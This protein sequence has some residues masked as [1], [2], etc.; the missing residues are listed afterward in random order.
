MDESSAA[1]L[2]DKAEVSHMPFCFKNPNAEDCEDDP[3]YYQYTVDVAPNAVFL[4]LCTVSLIGILGTWV[5]TRRGTAFNVAMILGLVCEIVGYAARIANWR[6][7][8]DLTAFITQICCLTMGPA[9]MAAGIYLCLRR[10]VT[11]F[12]P[13]NSRLPPEY[14]TRF[15]I[16]C[17]IV[18]LFLQAFGGGVVAVAAQQYRSTR[19]GT[20]IMIAGLASQAATILVF[21]I[22]SADFALRSIRRQRV[23]G[24]AAFDQRAEIA[25]VRNSRRFQSF[26][27][28]LSLSA[29][30]ILS[31]SAFR[32]AELSQGWTGSLMGNQT[33]FIIF[34]GIL[35]VVAVISLNI[36][37]PS[38]CM[39]ELLELEGGGLKGIWGFRIRNEATANGGPVEYHRK[40]PTSESVAI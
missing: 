9:F 17:D 19:L 22:C 35:I 5:I 16:P 4:A 39:K 31:R 37:H 3:G 8:F 21:I 26:I 11:A 18:S 2:F 7:R 38:F 27:C 33:L 28:A 13:E 20:D 29:I 34:E 10:I 14:Y 30:C 12:G 15:F 36:F 25:E 24:E 23:L 1:F 40:T 6:N 32:V